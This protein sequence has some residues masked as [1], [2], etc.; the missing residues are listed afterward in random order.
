[1]EYGGQ[2]PS[3][4]GAD[5]GGSASQRPG[6][7]N[8]AKKWRY[9]ITDTLPDQFGV[10]IVLGAGHAVGHHRAQQ[11]LDGAQQGNRHGRT[12]Q[13]LDQPQRQ[14]QRLTIRTG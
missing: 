5:V 3:C 8:A 11:R 14:P 13:I 7:G 2:R 10:G 4:A 9:R 12:Q 6:R 1:M